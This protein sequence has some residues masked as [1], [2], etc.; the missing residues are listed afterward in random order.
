MLYWG[1]VEV[2]IEFLIYLGNKSQAHMAAADWL[3][4]YELKL[5]MKNRRN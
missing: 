3:A 1:Y 5:I 2:I 4:R